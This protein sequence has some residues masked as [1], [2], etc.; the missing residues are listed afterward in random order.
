MINSCIQVGVFEGLSNQSTL[1]RVIAVCN[2]FDGVDIHAR[3]VGDI[4]SNGDLCRKIKLWIQS[5][6]SVACC[7]A[8][9]GAELPYPRRTGGGAVEACLNTIAFICVIISYK[10]DLQIRWRQKNIPLI[11]GNFKSTS[12]TTPVTSNPLTSMYS[13]SALKDD[14]D[15]IH[16][17]DAAAVCGFV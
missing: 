5:A 9:G 12:V 16:T 15:I 14:S 8:V 1:L 13:I 2:K 10:E 3:G 17:S 4:D 11:S 7:D 6:S